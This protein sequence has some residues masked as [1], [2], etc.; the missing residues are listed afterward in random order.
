[1]FIINIP[2]N[3]SDL[4]RCQF[5]LA[6]ILF[7]MI[8]YSYNLRAQTVNWSQPVGS[9]KKTPYMRILGSDETGGFYV[10]KSSLS[11]DDQR[12]KPI[13]KAR[14]YSLQYFSEDLKHIW[15]KELQTS[16]EDGYLTDLKM[17]NNRLL[18]T[19][20]I[21][22]KK[23]KEYSF[24]A[25][26]LSS[27]GEWEGKPVLIEKFI[28]ARSSDDEKPEMIISHNLKYWAFI[29]RLVSADKNSQ[30]FNFVILDTNMNIISKKLFQ[31]DVPD[32][33]FTPVKFELS[34][35]AS[36]YL[37]GLRYTTKKRIKSPGESFFE[38][39]GYNVAAGEMNKTNIRS[40][41][42]FLTDV[43]MTVD[44]LNHR[45]VVSGFYSDR[46]N[47]T[48]SGVFYCSMS[49]DS[50]VNS[51]I[52]TSP[53]SQA[54]LQRFPGE[55]KDNK[56]H[57]LTNYSIDRLI[58]RKDGGVALVAES[59]Y[60]TSRSYFDFYSQSYVS[61][62]YY[63]YGNIMLLSINPDGNILWSNVISKD[64]NSTNDGG[65]YSSYFL[66]VTNGRLKTIF[67][68]YIDEDSSVLI[69]D[70]DAK[71]EQKTDVLFNQYE[72]I[73]VIPFAARQVDDETVLMPAYKEN[74]FYI[75]KISF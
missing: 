40:E 18:I 7:L 22:D 74:K 10:L 65:F 56:T 69:G 51:P 61:V 6:A 36:L 73:T 68:K 75:L 12:H 20:F 42:Q 19:G 55:P 23:V 46:T 71:G 37:L 54:F 49:E 33:L 26:Y 15:E 59:F 2:F 47:Y 16:Y 8:L 64:Q 62:N 14:V 57:E 27:K 67:N 43:G 35:E 52:F 25:Q 24:Y 53:F 48:T 50:L 70:V 41:S 21:F 1:M 72:K 45:I 34:D 63:H 44:N 30:E 32:K 66:A 3:R 38:L 17:I 4:R 13:F 60:E 39:Y 5:F 11:A 29:Y 9:S 28:A 31:V 58:V